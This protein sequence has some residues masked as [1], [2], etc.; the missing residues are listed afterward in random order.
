M[1]SQGRG[2]CL[3]DIERNE[4]IYRK[5]I[6]N[7]FYVRQLNDSTW[8]TT[9]EDKSNQYNFDKS[10]SIRLTKVDSKGIESESLTFNPAIP[11]LPIYS[12]QMISDQIVGLVARYKTYFWNFRTNQK[13]CEFLTNEPGFLS[14]G[15]NFLLSSKSQ[16]ICIDSQTFD[17][18]WKLDV[19][20]P[21]SIIEYE[22]K[23]KIYLLNN[24][25]DCKNQCDATQV[26]I[27]NKAD[28]SLEPY[29]FFVSPFYCDQKKIYDS[30]HGLVFIRDN[31]ICSFAVGGVERFKITD[32]SSIESWRSM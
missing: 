8:I 12:C 16:L 3:Y 9:I 6:P 4:V 27:V 17:T 23:D 1:C 25:I 15:M 18:V 20:I 28:N 31:N 29:E 14:S 32:I 7:W 13:L 22:T 19:A 21:H 10:G 11:N 5:Q 24:V 2:L 26:K 30:P